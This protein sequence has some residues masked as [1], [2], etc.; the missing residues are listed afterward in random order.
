MMNQEDVPS[1]VTSEIP[2]MGQEMKDNIKNASIYQIMHQLVNYTNG[3]LQQNNFS[4]A[5]KCFQVVSKLYSQGNKA[6]KCAIENTYVYALDKT[7]MSYNSNRER[8]IGLIPHDLYSIYVRQ[9]IC[10]NI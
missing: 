1:Y 8:I 3:Q 7:I 9:I 10:S 6:V 2:E 5:G 4:Y